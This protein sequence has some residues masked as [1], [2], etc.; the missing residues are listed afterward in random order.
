MVEQVVKV[1]ILKLG[2]V[3]SAPLLEFLLD[4]RAERKDID[5]RVVGSG[6]KL[7]PDF[8]EDA[9]KKLLD[10]SP[11]FA[12]VVSPNATLPGPTKAREIL[13]GA[14]LPTVVISDAPTKR[15]VKDLETAGFGY[16]IV[17]ADSMIGARREFLDPVEMALFN[18]DM[19]TVLA[20]TG[21]YNIIYESI[22]K[23]IQA[24]KEGKEPELP[25]IVV[26]KEKAVA[27]AEFKN[28]YAKAKAMSAFEIAK[29][30]VDLKVEGCFKV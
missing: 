22:D 24:V 26:N 14:G 7:S 21:V 30:V 13:K 3:G 4:E 9:A 10:F 16:I 29:K 1:G 17:E 25:K 20:A 19:I 12:I 6:A 8:A 23:M 5:V 28:P 18:A 2:C 27:A 11:H 15:I